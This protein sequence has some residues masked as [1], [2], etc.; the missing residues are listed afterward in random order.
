VLAR[1]GAT[2]DAAEVIRSIPPGEAKDE[3]V[4][5]LAEAFARA[6]D[7][8][9]ALATLGSL[10]IAPRAGYSPPMDAWFVAVAH[11]TDHLERARPGLVG[12]LLSSALDVAGWIR[13]D[14]AKVARVVGDAISGRKTDEARSTA[15]VPCDGTAE[16]M[17]SVPSSALA[18]S[19]VT[20][21]PPGKAIP[22]R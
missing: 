9:N 10:P 16:T 8:V 2:S 20:E 1:A 12:P 22:G 17:K 13:P 7:P 6:G 19:V 15:R 4:R 11:W 3:A 5:E 21:R 14:W 18:R